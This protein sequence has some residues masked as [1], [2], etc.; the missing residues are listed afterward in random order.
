[1]IPLMRPTSNPKTSTTANMIQGLIPKRVVPIA[2]MIE[3]APITEP[4]DRSNS[5]A[6]IRMPTASAMMPS[7]ADVLSH[8]AVPFSETKSACQ[9]ATAKKM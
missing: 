5:P 7:S 4:I 2:S 1:M 3:L 6:I 9:A 8:A